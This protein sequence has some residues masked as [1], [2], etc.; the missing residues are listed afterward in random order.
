MGLPYLD[1]IKISFLD[2]KASE[3]LE[4]RQNR[5]DFINDI[6][7]SFKDEVITKTG[8]LKKQWQGKIL[9]Q[10]HPYLNIEYFGILM[11]TTN[12]LLSTSALRYKKVRQAINYS[13]NRK[14]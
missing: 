5:L 4:F 11:D 8:N 9:L 14:K 12:S 3:F 1:G 6:E 2:S 10:K 13:I 7:A